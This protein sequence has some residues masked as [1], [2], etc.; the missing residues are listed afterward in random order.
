MILT[1]HLMSQS[2]SFGNAPVW[3]LLQENFALP[4]SGPKGRS[5]LS[6]TMKT[7]AAVICAKNSP[8]R[9]ILRS[10]DSQFSGVIRL[11]CKTSDWRMISSNS[12]L[13]APLPKL[14]NS[15]PVLRAGRFAVLPPFELRASHCRRIQP[16]GERSR[17]QSGNGG[18]ID[19]TSVAL[20][21][22]EKRRI[23]EGAENKIQRH[24]VILAAYLG[25]HAAGAI[26]SQTQSRRV[27]LNVSASV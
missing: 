14:N 11:N 15:S 1:D 26:L 23:G 8:C 12:S 24:G 10:G 25:N 6:S 17:T 13:V 7:L 16:G 3:Q 20:A 19:H 2:Y 9:L 5:G 22:R 18:N 4:V 21:N 27:S